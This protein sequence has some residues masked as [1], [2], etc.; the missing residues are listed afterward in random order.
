MTNFENDK[1]FKITYF[2]EK[3]RDC[4][5]KAISASNKASAIRIFKVIMQAHGY[6]ETDYKIERITKGV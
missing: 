5:V 1:Q 2:D 6:S 4:E 3:T